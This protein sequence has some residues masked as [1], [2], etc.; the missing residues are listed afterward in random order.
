VQGSDIERWNPVEG[1]IAPGAEN[2]TLYARQTAN[3]RA[4]YDRTK[5]L[6]AGLDQIT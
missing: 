4:V 5:D 2:R 3:W 1:K 6:M